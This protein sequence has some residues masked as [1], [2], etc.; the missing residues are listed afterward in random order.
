MFSV[1]WPVRIHAGD[2]NRI[3]VVYDTGGE[4][5]LTGPAVHAQRI[6]LGQRLLRL[7]GHQGLV[8]VVDG[9]LRRGRDVEVHP[10]GKINR[11]RCR[12]PY[13]G[14]DIGEGESENTIINHQSTLEPYRLFIAHAAPIHI[15][16]LEEFLRNI[17]HLGIDHVAQIGDVVAVIIRLQLLALLAVL[18]GE[19]DPGL[20]DGLG[21]RIADHCV[22]IFTTF[23]HQFHAQTAILVAAALQ[24]HE[25]GAVR[26]GDLLANSAL[27]HEVPFPTQ[28]AVDFRRIG[29][30]G[31]QLCGDGVAEQRFACAQ[32]DF[33]GVKA[34]AGV[35]PFG[36][37]GILLAVRIDAELLRID[38]VESVA[39]QANTF[40]RDPCAC[41][42]LH[43]GNLIPGG[44]HELQ[45]CVYRALAVRRREMDVPSTR[46]GLE[47]W[48]IIAEADAA[49]IRRPREARGEDHLALVGISSIFHR[50]RQ[51]PRAALRVHRHFMLFAIRRI[52]RFTRFGVAR[53]RQRGDRDPVE[54]TVQLQ[55]ERFLIIIQPRRD[56][57]PDAQLA[58]E[59]A[60][61]VHR[62]DGQA[63][64]A[65]GDGVRAV[66]KRGGLHVLTVDLPRQ[67][68]ACRGVN[69]EDFAPEQRVLAAEYVP[70][71]NVQVNPLARLDGGHVAPPG[72]EHARVIAAGGAHGQRHI[73]TGGNRNRVA[74]VQLPEARSGDAVPEFQGRIGVPA[75]GHLARIA[76]LGNRHADFLRRIGAG[77][78]QIIGAGG[79]IGMK[80]VIKFQ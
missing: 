5:V 72:G 22:F 66:H 24:N 58:G 37:K 27:V 18:A 9:H 10:A 50:D 77:E 47:D 44:I 60:G 52:D 3:L 28:V 15:C 42:A 59:A 57:A 74:A 30:A 8:L 53:D 45:G 73:R 69:F 56:R 14:A 36:G 35:E 61:S 78:L 1:V 54:I 26:T 13:D 19:D 40:G 63:G 4:D 34:Q 2:R 70:A 20:G 6:H 64:D 76:A 46:Y 12:F 49:E 55:N 39:V 16:I 38:A 31:R 80:S 79:V 71:G 21:L 75:E 68:R 23:V 33:T 65:P 48:R 41:D 62:R 51:R 32:I 29:H 7:R 17:L 25:A 11:L 67:G 43:V